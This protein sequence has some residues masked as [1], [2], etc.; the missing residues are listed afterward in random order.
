MLVMKNFFIFL[1]LLLLS[2]NFSFAYY[3][4]VQL[5]VDDSGILYIDGI[6][7]HPDLLIDESSEFTFK[8]GSYWLFNFSVDGE[9]SDLSYEINLPE[10]AVI[11]YMKLPVFGRIEDKGGITLTGATQ[12]SSLFIAVQYKI[13][14]SSSLI[15][16]WSIF[17]ILGFISLGI[18]GF[19]YATGRKKSSY[20][21]SKYS[22]R[23]SMILSLLLKNGGEITQAELERLTGLP[24]SS[25][26]RNIDSLV[27]KNV[28]EKFQKGMSN[29]VRLKPLI[30]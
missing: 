27:R 24:K 5:T 11:N 26:S 30:K 29:T 19:F 21:L 8:D 17:L 1:F 28:V 6:T 4:D 25:L 7:N 23:Q 15:S 14:R 10:G 18:A 22:S 9:F 20:D 12:N 13:K 2:V 16:W 3:A